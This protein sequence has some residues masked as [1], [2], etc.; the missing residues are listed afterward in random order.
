MRRTDTTPGAVVTR[1]LLSPAGARVGPLPPASRKAGSPTETPVRVGP[2][3]Q[4][5]ESA[6]P[7]PSFARPGRMVRDGP[8]G[9][10]A[11]QSE[12]AK[13]FSRPGSRALFSL[14][15]PSGLDGERTDTHAHTYT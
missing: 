9:R 12:S 14:W 10:A 6:N 2:E 11:F 13:T 7:D 15:A 5:A 8:A 4:P 1:T 3:F